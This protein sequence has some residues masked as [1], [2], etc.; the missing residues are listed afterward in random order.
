M[1]MYDQIR[2]KVEELGGSSSAFGSINVN[3][4]REI[5][6]RYQPLPAPGYRV[7][8]VVPYLIGSADPSGTT[9]PPLNDQRVLAWQYDP[10][11]GRPAPPA[12]RCFKLGQIAQILPS[13]KPRPATLPVLDEGGQNCVR[14]R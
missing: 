2:A 5:K 10:D 4:G 11:P 3:G 12:W 6:I 14:S 13:P 7:V 1:A 9:T 8:S